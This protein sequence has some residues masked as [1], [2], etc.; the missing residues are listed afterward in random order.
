ME[1]KVNLYGASGHSKVIADIVLSNNFIIDKIIDDN[2]K[3]NTVLGIKVYKNT[4]ADFDDNSKW[5]ISIGNNKV[6]KMLSTK[7]NLNFTSAVHKNALI[8]NYSTLDVGTVIM[9]GAIVNPDVKIGKHCIINT[10]AVIEHDCVIG[11]FVHISPN[12]S[13]AG[14]V[15]IGEGS[16]VG[17]GATIIQGVSVGNWVTIG[18]GTVILKDV[19]DFVTIVGNPGRIIKNKQEN[20]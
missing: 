13:L 18:A 7:L 19:P 12:A 9:A 3:L 15:T 6:R 20:E 1:N 17:I 10:N 5:I 8:S 2:P 14:G 11:D 4:N 16:H